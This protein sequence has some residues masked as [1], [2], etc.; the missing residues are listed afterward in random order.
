MGVPFQTQSVKTHAGSFIYFPIRSG[1]T[2]GPGA[3]GTI[4][5]T[6]APSELRPLPC[7]IAQLQLSLTGSQLGSGIRLPECNASPWFFLA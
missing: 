7:Q 4:L 5:G 6:K 3:C 1:G 2:R